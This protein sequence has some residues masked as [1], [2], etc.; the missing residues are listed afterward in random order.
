MD[1]PEH[2][3]DL[4]PDHLPAV[5]RMRFGLSLLLDRRSPEWQA[6][7]LGE[8]LDQ[9]IWIE[10]LTGP[11]RPGAVAPP[12]PWRDQLA[13]LQR[14]I[15]LTPLFELADWAALDRPQRLVQYHQLRQTFAHFFARRIQDLPFSERIRVSDPFAQTIWFDGEEKQVESPAAFEVLARLIEAGGGLVSREELLELPQCDGV[16]ISRVI[17]EHIKRVFGDI[18]ASKRGNGGGRWIRLPSRSA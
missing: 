5:G 11:V 4:D 13:Q 7:E 3:P 17:K 14:E 10:Q 2:D 9:G 18:I 16:K 12:D 15:G 8:K 1:N 6:L